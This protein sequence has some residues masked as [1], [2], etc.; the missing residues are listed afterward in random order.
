M[1]CLY[2]YAIQQHSFAQHTIIVHIVWNNSELDQ[3]VQEEIP[4]DYWFCLNIFIIFMTISWQIQTLLHKMLWKYRLN[5]RIKQGRHCHIRILLIICQAC[6]QR[7]IIL[8]VSLLWL[9][10]LCTHDVAI[11][12]QYI[13]DE[14]VSNWMM[15]NI[16]GYRSLGPELRIYE[17]KIIDWLI[18]LNPTSTIPLTVS[19]MYYVLYVTFYVCT[20]HHHHVSYMLCSYISYIATKVAT[21]L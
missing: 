4:F 7:Y 3:N 20:V 15:R 21:Y 9:R 18:A 19:F 1:F 8:L 11:F 17:F 14:W 16:F 13:I 12:M 2:T 10:I 6:I 5:I